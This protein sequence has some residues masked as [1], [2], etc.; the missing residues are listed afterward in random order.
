MPRSPAQTEA[1]EPTWYAMLKVVAPDGTATRTTSLVV[2]L[3][4][5]APPIVNPVEKFKDVKQVQFWTVAVPVNAEFCFSIVTTVRVG[6]MVSGFRVEFMVTERVP[7][8][9]LL[10]VAAHVPVSPRESV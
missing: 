1:D 4:V 10:C 2:S 8:G 5:N 9:A 3:R 6:E 7:A